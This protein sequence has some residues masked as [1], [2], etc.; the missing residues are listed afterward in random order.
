MRTS[1]SLRRRD[2]Q[3]YEKSRGDL[4]ILTE[5][6]GEKNEREHPDSVNSWLDKL[7]ARHPELP[8]INPHAFRHSMAT[9]LLANGMDIVG[10]SRRLGHAK[11]STTVNIYAHLVDESDKNNSDALERLYAEER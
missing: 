6:H 2:P 7:N 3:K 9:T 8:K 11:P 4:R 1:L 5:P 10:V